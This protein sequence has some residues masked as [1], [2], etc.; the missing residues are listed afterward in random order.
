MISSFFFSSCCVRS[1]KLENVRSKTYDGSLKFMQHSFDFKKHHH[2]LWKLSE[3]DCE[4]EHFLRNDSSRMPSIIYLHNTNTINEICYWVVHRNR[5]S[6]E[7]RFHW[8][9]WVYASCEFSFCCLVFRVVSIWLNIVAHQKTKTFQ[10]Q[11]NVLSINST[12]YIP[13]TCI[14]CYKKHASCMQSY[15]ESL[16]DHPFFQMRIR[17]ATNVVNFVAHFIPF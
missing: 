4:N 10:L 1:S 12:R 6:F 16:N 13:I 5:F 14:W 8:F 7:N 17:C 11:I 15:R 2:H 3:N 9:V